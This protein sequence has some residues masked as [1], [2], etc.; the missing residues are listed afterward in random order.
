VNS[1]NVILEYFK[2]ESDQSTLKH[3]LQEL[4]F[5]TPYVSSSNLRQPASYLEEYWEYYFALP[6]DSGLKSKTLFFTLST[7]HL[8]FGCGYVIPQEEKNSVSV[9][10]YLGQT[11]VSLF[12]SNDIAKHMMHAIFNLLAAD[13]E[14]AKTS[15]FLKTSGFQA[16]P[17]FHRDL[18]KNHRQFLALLYSDISDVR[19]FE[20]ICLVEISNQK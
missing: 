20:N 15:I 18:A 16:S 9:A 11:F 4:N 5:D 19:F 2:E 13:A 12:G 7:Q 3:R 8:T 1:S 6:K 17:A 10:L 14:V